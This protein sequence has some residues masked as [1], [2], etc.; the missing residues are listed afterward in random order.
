MKSVVDLMSNVQTNL[1]SQDENYVQAMQDYISIF[2]MEID[3]KVDSAE[4]MLEYILAAETSQTNAYQP[5]NKF[6]G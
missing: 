5:I 4:S 3:E 1:P 2:N 6:I